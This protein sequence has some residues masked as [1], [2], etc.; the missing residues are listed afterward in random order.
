MSSATD[1]FT[2]L[3]EIGVPAERI[4]L[5]G[6]GARSP[7]WRQIQ[8]DVYAHDVETVTA[9]EGAAYGAA[10]SGGR[11]LRMLGECR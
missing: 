3:E 4:R 11:G 1:T 7:L 2:I 10:I 6:R 8:A 5:G 9:E